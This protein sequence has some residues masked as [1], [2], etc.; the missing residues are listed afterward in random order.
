M[1]NKK[2]IGAVGSMTLHH[3]LSKPGVGAAGGRGGFAYND[4]SGPCKTCK[5]QE[6]EGEKSSVLLSG[7]VHMGIW[8]N[9]RWD[10]RH[11]RVHQLC[12]HQCFLLLLRA[13]LWCPA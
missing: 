6:T 13:F 12:R 11:V 3:Y 10:A 2:K 8:V 4:R 1:Y 9:G 7:Q 5:E